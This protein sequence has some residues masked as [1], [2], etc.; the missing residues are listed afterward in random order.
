MPK[1]GYDNYR[2]SAEMRNVVMDNERY[3]G[4]KH[5]PNC[6]HR[7]R[8]GKHENIKPTPGVFLAFVLI[9]NNKWLTAVLSP[10][11]L[12]L[13]HI[14]FIANHKKI[15]YPLMSPASAPHGEREGFW[16]RP[17]ERIVFVSMILSIC[18]IDML[19]FTL[20]TIWIGLCAIQIIGNGSRVGI[21]SAEMRFSSFDE[22]FLLNLT[23]LNYKK[24]LD[25]D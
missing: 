2:Q 25:F 11:F 23:L 24:K 3:R 1:G 13:N 9:A 21:V 17:G 15:Y 12:R 20:I 10:M 19:V 4:L 8:W 18:R 14:I 16:T 5:P 22:Q 6:P 7:R